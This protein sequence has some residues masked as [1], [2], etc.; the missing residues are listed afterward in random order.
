M[1]KRKITVKVVKVKL[2]KDVKHFSVWQLVVFALVFAGI[3]GYAIWHSFAETGTT[4]IAADDF[5]RPDSNPVSGNWET[6]P[7]VY[8]MQIISDQL[9]KSNDTQQAWE[10]TYNGSLWKD[11]IPSDS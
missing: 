6:R 10:A 11:A 5:N 1:L 4:V 8:P 9:A 7:G 3:G 2:L